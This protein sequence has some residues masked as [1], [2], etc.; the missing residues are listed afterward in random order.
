VSWRRVDSLIHEIAFK[1]LEQINVKQINRVARRFEKKIRPNFE[2][3][4][5]TFFR[6]KNVNPQ[7]KSAKTSTPNHILKN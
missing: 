4:A 7:F 6:P 5:K 3:V 2:K 1:I